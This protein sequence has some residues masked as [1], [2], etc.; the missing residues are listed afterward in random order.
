MRRQGG[1]NKQKA[2]L[3]L[4]DVPLPGVTLTEIADNK[5]VL[6]EHHNG[7]GAYSHHE[8]RVNVKNGYNA[9]EGSHLELHCISGEKIVVTGNITCVRFCRED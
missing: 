8:I 4:Q 1:M 5:R 6:I 3:V 9:I 7:I 2:H